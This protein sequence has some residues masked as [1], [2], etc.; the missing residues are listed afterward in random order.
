VNVTVLG[1][2]I[3]GAGMARSLLRAGHAVTVWNRTAAKAAPL[4]DDG[5][6]VAGTAAEAVAGAE[7]V[8][9]MLFDTAAV[10]DV[11]T[12]ASARKTDAVWLQASTIGPEGMLE[13]AALAAGRGLRLVDAPVL[14]TK[15]PAEQGTLV[16][17]LS[18]DE[19]S[20][21]AARPVIEGYSAR[22]VNAGP[23]L[24]A[25]SALKLVCNAWI[26]SVNAAVGQSYALAQGLGIDPGL[27]AEAIRGG[28]ADNPYLHMKGDLI[29]KGEFPPSFTL[30]GAA[31]DVE[32]ILAAARGAGVG[33]DVLAGLAAAYRR[34][35]ADHGE[36][37]M[38]A[39]YYAFPP[40]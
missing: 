14:G 21:E 15:G 18:G 24:G 32:L 25:A 5:A 37:D 38:A 31:K 28:A 40:A 4:A 7:V 11:L 26:S 19:A 35:A 16:A 6:T 10:L 39:V 36:E 17:L 8:L 12:A 29:A 33:D 13:V 3:M 9:V 23:S 27:F 30:D 34:A 1:T 2:G 20:V 22:S